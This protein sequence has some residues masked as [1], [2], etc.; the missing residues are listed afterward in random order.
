MFGV[1]AA[2]VTIRSSKFN[3]TVK[4]A[5]EKS[6]IASV[7]KY[8]QHFNRFSVKHFTFFWHRKAA[9]M[10]SWHFHKTLP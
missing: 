6:N 1:E 7:L 2:K 4:T 10:S 3:A 9:E 5:K 8:L